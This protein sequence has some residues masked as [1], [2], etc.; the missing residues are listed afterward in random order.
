MSIGLLVDF[1]LHVAHQYYESKKIGRTEKCRDVICKM[2]WAV[3]QGGLSTFLGVMPLALAA[4]DVLRVI[5]ISFVGIVT[6]GLGH[7]LI[8]FPV[9]L[10]YVGPL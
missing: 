9:I 10:S 1:I 4:N 5:F 2:G 8:L 6:L 7:G 3:L